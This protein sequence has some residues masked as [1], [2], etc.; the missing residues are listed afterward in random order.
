MK[1]I[2]RYLV[3]ILVVA[4]CSKND[5]DTTE[6]G[7]FPDTISLA[8]NDGQQVVYRIR[9]TN[10]NQ[11]DQIGIERRFDDGVISRIES[12]FNYSAAG[13]LTEVSSTF[14]DSN[15]RIAF[16]YDND[17]TITNLDFIVDGTEIGMDIFYLG[18][19]VNAYSINGSL[20]NLPTAWDFDS[21]NILQEFAVTSTSIVPTY[22]DFGKGV[23]NDVSIQPATHIWYGLLFYLAPWE[24]YLFSTKDMERLRIADD[25]YLYKNKLRDGEDNLVAF[26]FG[27]QNLLGLTINYTITYENRSLQK[28]L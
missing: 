11:I 6:Q 1:S 27:S 21:E 17:T 15:L 22:S 20:G 4:S 8:Y 13:E 3:I 5:N 28:Q 9:Y 7:Y 24:L 12:T 14:D 18:K 23:F 26:Q 25:T 2:I 16:M 19:A 10:D